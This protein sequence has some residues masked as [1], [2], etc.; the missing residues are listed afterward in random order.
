M[1]GDDPELA[2][3]SAG[4][5]MEMKREAEPKKLQPM[6]KLHDIFEMWKGSQNLRA[7]QEETRTQNK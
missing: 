3:T 2:L 6:A 7:T 5:D 4:N 1:A